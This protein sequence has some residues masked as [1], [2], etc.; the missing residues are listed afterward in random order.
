MIDID[1]LKLWSTEDLADIF[2]TS[3]RTIREHFK[4]RGISGTRIGQK[5]YYTSTKVGLLFTPPPLPLSHQPPSPK[6]F[7]KFHAYER[8]R[9]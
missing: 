4:R 3:E 9:T 6:A 2:E 7:S 8:D 1:G 5:T